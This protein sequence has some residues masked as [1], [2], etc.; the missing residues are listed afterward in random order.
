MGR[1]KPEVELPESVREEIALAHTVEEAVARV[2]PVQRVHASDTE[3]AAVVEQVLTELAA[4]EGPAPEEGP[5]I[6]IPIVFLDALEVTQEVQDL[7]H[8]VPLIVEKATIVRVY[9]RYAPAAGRGARRLAHGA[10]AVRTVADGAVGRP[11]AARPVE[12]GRVARRAP[13]APRRTL[14]FSLNFRVPL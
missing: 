5:A 7:A 9:L 12:V 1:M 4:P 6:T 10:P 3:T 11:G 8:S 2:A 14:G 13:F